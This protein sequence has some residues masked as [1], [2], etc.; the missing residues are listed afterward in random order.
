MYDGKEWNQQ[1]GI[2][3][4]HDTAGKER[5]ASQYNH[6]VVHVS[7]NDA[8]AYC[9]WRSA[10]EG[11]TYRLPTEAEWEYACRAGSKT[12]TPFNTGGNLT[13]AQANY[14]GNYPYGKNSKGQFRGTTVA[15]NRFAPN[16]W[17]LY[18]MHG[19][20]WEW[21]SDWYGEKY[22]EECKAQGVVENPQGAEGV[23]KIVRTVL[24][25]AGAGTTTPRTVGLRIATATLPTTGTSMLASAWCSSRSQLA[26]HSGF[27]FELKAEPK[28]RLRR[29]AVRDEL[30]HT[31]TEQV[32]AGTTEKVALW[33]P[34][35]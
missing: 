26:A 27:A 2:N 16:A 9:E 11:K 17:G 8:V 4:R 12:T 19:N 28:T 7:W 35:F 23:V 15:V 1:K 34:N 10:K 6:P 33:R 5:P 13:T 18:N 31:S 29:A 25:V 24:S 3:W 22:Y 14:D 21:C 32:G 20:V 30:P